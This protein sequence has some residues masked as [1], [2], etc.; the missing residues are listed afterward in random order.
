MAWK[1]RTGGRISQEHVEFSSDSQLNHFEFGKPPNMKF[2]GKLAFQVLKFAKDLWQILRSTRRFLVLYLMFL[3]FSFCCQALRCLLPKNKR[4]PRPVL[5]IPN[6]VHLAFR[7]SNSRLAEFLHRYSRNATKEHVFSIA[8]TM[9]H[10]TLSLITLLFSCEQG[11][12][13]LTSQRSR[14][15]ALFQGLLAMLYLAQYLRE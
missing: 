13:I 11:L 3:I 9:W 4:K 15:K 12:L 8:A 6:H 2:L 5:T 7:R 10:S 14:V 1:D